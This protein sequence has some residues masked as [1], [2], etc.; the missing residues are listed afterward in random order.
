MSKIKRFV[1]AMATTALLASIVPTASVFAAPPIDV[2]GTQYEEA[3]KVLGA[4]NIMVGDGVAFRAED[5]I[6]RS[7][8]T[9]I[10]VALKGLT[11]AANA[12]TQTK[13][14]DVAQGHWA[15]GFIN[16]GTSEGLVVGD[17]LGNFRPNDN[18]SYNEAVTILVRA[19]GYEPQAQSKGGYPGGYLSAGSSTGLTSGVVIARNAAPTTRGQV[20]LLAYNAMNINL[21]EQTGFGDKVNYEITDETPVTAFHDAQKIEGVVTAV[22]NSAIEG[23]GVEKDEI[24]I[25]KKVYKTG[26]ADVRNVLGLTVDAYIAKNSKNKDTVK[27]VVPSKYKNSVTTI[28]ADDLDSVNKTSD[29]VT[30]NY[31][32]N[33]KKTKVNIS[34]DSYVV[35]NGKAGTLDDIS[36]I[37]SGAVMIADYDKDKNIVFVNDTVNYVVDEVVLTSDRII[38]KYG[39]TPLTLDKEDDDLSFV[40]E[41]NGI[42]M[43]ISELKEWDVITFTISKD[44]TA[45]YGSVTNTELQGKVTEVESD[46]IYVE[47]KAYK[48]AKNYKEDIKLGD[49]GVFYLDAEGK[50]A[51]FSKGAKSERNYAYITNIGVASGLSGKLEIELLGLDGKVTKYTAENK[52]KVDTKT[53]STPS[54]A[55]KAI[56][57]KGQL[58]NVTINES[59]KVSHI[60]K[61]V[62]SD[63]IDENEFVL[64]FAGENVTY[65]EKTSALSGD[66]MNIRVD[67][68]TIVFDIPEK[69]VDTSDYSVTDKSIFSD[70]GKYDIVVYDMREDLT[71]GVII[72]TNAENKV[73][74][75]S[76]VMVV[77]KLTSSKDENG[78]ATVKVYGFIG[79][80]RVSVTGE[81]EMF[82]SVAKGDI[83]QVKADSKGV[84]KALNILFDYDKADTEFSKDVSD[85]LTIQYGKVTKKFASSFNLSVD[86]GAANNYSIGD[87]NIYVVDTASK[88]NPISV[89]SASDI[90]KFDDA[91]PERVFVRIYKGEVMDIVVVK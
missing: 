17:D 33:N 72:V 49:E 67:S 36:V 25:D 1:S 20:A 55:L 32:K 38:D 64:N 79:G 22:G 14:P 37:E 53:Y 62:E 54:E 66:G 89:G 43:E 78:D 35:Y 41:K 23:S 47:D 90:Q 6:T 65:T 71:A 39:N 27:V 76:P 44:K 56:G 70:G 3:A 12:N 85:D 69:S 16:V 2:M 11:D 91:K 13:F 75:M 46:K 45:I 26:N 5:P 74:D 86:G 31:F 77:E 68:E 52:I 28:L 4:F 18:I 81:K 61:S 29:G 30:I 8:V 73:N 7:E 57:S 82:E 34:K 48:V 80:E 9:K 51:A 60:A 87:A 15:T 84:V 19:L 63:D 83:I 58:V 42:P 50:I 24:V 40:I 59:G 88:N 10:A 21:M